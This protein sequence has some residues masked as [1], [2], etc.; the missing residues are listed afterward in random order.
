[1]ICSVEF[2]ICSD[3]NLCSCCRTRLDGRYVDLLIAAKLL[4][5]IAEHSRLSMAA[6]DDNPDGFAIPGVRERRPF[7]PMISYVYI[8]LAII[9]S[10]AVFYT[11]GYE[12]LIVIMLFF[13]IDAL[14]I[15]RYILK[16]SVRSFAR[17]ASYYNIAL[18]IV[19][20]AILFVNGFSFVRSGT[21]LILPG[22]E[23][24]T[25]ACPLLILSAEFGLMN[26][27]GMFMKEP[28]KKE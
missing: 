20:F 5:F 1:M 18:S 16:N 25:L 14:R 8:A 26:I 2:L 3:A 11:L 15:A 13:T 9:I 17:R 27:R 23:N 12:A 21:Y 10:Y 6:L 22:I 4:A 28:E 7:N 24:F 19:S